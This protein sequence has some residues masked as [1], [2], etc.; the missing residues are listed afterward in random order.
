MTVRQKLEIIQKMLGLTQTKLAEKFGVSFVTFNN[1]RTGKFSPRSKMQ[2][3]IDE[4]F[5]EA[6]GQKIIP[7]NQLIAKKQI[8]RQKS[9]KYKSTIAK[10][11]SN[12]DICNQFVLKLTYNSNRIEGS[13]LSESDTA[14]IL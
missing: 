14:A 1:W 2:I 3:A 4:L 13:T 7:A 9:L 8:L 5:I 10:I 6:T 11:L 12:I